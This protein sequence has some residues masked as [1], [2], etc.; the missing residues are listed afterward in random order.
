MRDKIRH[1]YIKEIKQKWGFNFVL[2]VE[3]LCSV[4]HAELLGIITSVWPVSMH[5]WPLSAMN[6]L[7]KNTQIYFQKLLVNDN[8]FTYYISQII[9]E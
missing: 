8:N 6:M 3:K 5:G 1:R 7:L 9:S 2:K 4:L